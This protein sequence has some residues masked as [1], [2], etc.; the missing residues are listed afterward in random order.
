MTL[1]LSLLVG[2]LEGAI[3]LLNMGFKLLTRI[4]S[5]TCID[6][7]LPLGGSGNQCVVKTDGGIYPVTNTSHSTSDHIK[8]TIPLVSFEVGML[9]GLVITIC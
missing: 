5:K 6:L 1:I 2:H 3:L 8:Y 7:S 9:T 4:S